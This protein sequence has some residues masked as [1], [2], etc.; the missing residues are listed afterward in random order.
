MKGL[1]IVLARMKSNPEE[2]YETRP[3]WRWIFQE[4]MVA[5]LTDDEKKQLIEGLR[6][7]RRHEYTERAIKTLLPEE[8]THGHVG[9][10]AQAQTMPYQYATTGSSNGT[11]MRLDANGNLGIG[12]AN[13]R[14]TLSIANETLDAE[15]LR[16]LKE[17][18]R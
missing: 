5:S 16:K 2:F 18:I 4:E 7:V 13:P 3:K 12:T 15:T 11:A 6:E 17:L 9:I 1:E 14:A 10:I 8:D